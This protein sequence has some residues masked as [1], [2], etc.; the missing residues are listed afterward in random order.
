MTETDNKSA[1]DIVIND[2][3]A[4]LQAYGN[5]SR[6]YSSSY[7]TFAI[8]YFLF[9]FPANVIDGTGHAT[10]NMA[11]AQRLDAAHGLRESRR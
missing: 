7:T 3:T 2:E 10:T 1:Q 9:L 4:L 5:M 6:L 8:G 11:A